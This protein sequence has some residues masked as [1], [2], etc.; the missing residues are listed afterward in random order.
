MQTCLDLLY[1]YKMDIL[2]IKPKHDGIFY[3]PCIAE[4]YFILVDLS[5][6]KLV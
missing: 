5:Y 4:C 6:T 1:I 3:G 2:Y